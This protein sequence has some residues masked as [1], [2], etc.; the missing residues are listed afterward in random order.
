MASISARDMVSSFAHIMAFPSFSVYFSFACFSLLLLPCSIRTYGISV[1]RCSI[2]IHRPI[3][4][5]IVTA[6]L[7]FLP[8]IFYHCAFLVKVPGFSLLNPALIVIGRIKDRLRLGLPAFLS[9]QIA[10]VDP[11]NGLLTAGL[12][13]RIIVEPVIKNTVHN[14]E[15]VYKRQLSLGNIG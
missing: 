1:R 2:N 9:F 14:I 10:Y 3:G 7:N 12:Q 6:A 13:I 15:D 4:A 8:G 11:V 5:E